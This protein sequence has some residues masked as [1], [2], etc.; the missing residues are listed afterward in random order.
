MP[1]PL[2]ARTRKSAAGKPDHLDFLCDVGELTAVVTDSADLG[3]CL[4]RLTTLVAQHLHTA[5]CSI[6]LADDSGQS[7]VLRATVGLNPAAVGTTRLKAGEGLAGQA[8]KELRPVLDNHASRNPQFKAFPA[9][10]EEPFDCFLAVPIHRGA[11]HIGVLCVQRRRNQPFQTEDAKALQT[12]ASQLAGLIGN[13]QAL[14]AQP[15]AGGGP[16][17]VRR[18]GMRL[19]RGQ[20]VSGGSATGPALV[21]A[22]GP[23]PAKTAVPEPAGGT[24]ADL[25]RAAEETARQIKDLQDRIARRLPEAAS[26]IFDAHLLMLH[27]D[28]FVG[29][30]RRL[31]R[32]GRPAR[33]AVRE[34]AAK[35][36]AIFAASPQAYLREKVKDIEDI[37]QRLLANLEPAARREESAAGSIVIARDL[38]PSDIVRRW[39]EGAKGFVLTSGGITTHVAILARSLQLPAVIADAPELAAVAPGT[40][41]LVDG[42][43]GNLYL[44]PR[45]DVLK[46]FAE[47][48]RTRTTAHQRAAEMRDST[49]TRDGERITLRANINLLGEVALARDLKAEGI[50]LYRTEFPFLIRTAFPTEEEQAALYARLVA[51]MPGRTVTFR[52]LDVGGEKALAYFNQGREAN[53]ELGLRSIRFCFRHPDIFTA[54]VRAILRA[55]ATAKVLRVM[56]PMIS[57]LDEFRAAR[58]VVLGCAEALRA[59]GIPHAAHPAIGMMIELPA[60]VELIDAFAAEADFFSVG[61]NDFV[62]YMLGADRGNELVADAYCPHHPAVLR[63]LAQVVAGAA[64]HGKELTVCGEMAHRPEYLPL[65]VGLG[66]RTF[67]VDPHHLPDMQARLAALDLTQAQALAREILADPTI[68]G[69]ARR[70]HLPAKPA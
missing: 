41:L 29:E 59:E 65:L 2:S 70:L 46:R 36:T 21:V 58:Q 15:A 14:L 63:A 48:E 52:T 22:A 45:A 28:G 56:F 26:L 5:V 37:A 27:D 47:G 49:F 62:Q 11:A 24:E 16:L 1:K 6:Y 23:S 68:A 3:A 19:L 30:M 20:P 25:A 54:Q 66:V 51:G 31:A 32:S 50:G 55:G 18:G 64:R 35:Y 69:I 44:Q 8:F 10:G 39:A 67:S 53:P 42:D 34:V 61:T 7:L 13:V 4:Q 38:Y 9:I 40:P 12:V 17:P 57:S 43:T 60:V 33:A